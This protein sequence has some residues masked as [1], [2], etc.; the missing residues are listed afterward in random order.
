MLQHDFSK[1]ARAFLFLNVLSQSAIWKTAQTVIVYLLS[2]DNQTPLSMRFPRQ[3][4]QNGLPFPSPGDLPGPGVEPTSSA[5]AGGFFSTEPPG[6]QLK[7]EWS[8]YT[9]PDLQIA[10]FGSFFFPHPFSNNSESHYV[11]LREVGIA[12]R[13]GRASGPEQS[14]GS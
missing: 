4:Y 10:H 7:P 2:H 1:V 12:A 6:A 11:R 14:G 8:G 5:Q 13:G 3:E 9:T